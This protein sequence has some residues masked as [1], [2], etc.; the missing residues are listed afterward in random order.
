MCW[1]GKNFLGFF[2]ALVNWLCHG[3]AVDDRWVQTLIFF[4]RR[5]KWCG[6]ESGYVVLPIPAFFFLISLFLLLLSW[7]ISRQHNF[8]A[9]ALVFLFV[10]KRNSTVATPKVFLAP[11]LR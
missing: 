9:I 7:K 10:G 6:G 1:R 4:L 11:D 3:T 2:F 5:E 8:N